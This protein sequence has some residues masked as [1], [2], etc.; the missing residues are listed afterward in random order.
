M[1]EKADKAR[2]A[3]ANLL[4]VI[5]DLE[6]ASDTIGEC[7]QAIKR[8]RE[9]L[10]RCQGAATAFERSDAVQAATLALSDEVAT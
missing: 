9:N 8:A 7:C 6:A 2:A 4:G 1:S 3:I 10:E 5:A